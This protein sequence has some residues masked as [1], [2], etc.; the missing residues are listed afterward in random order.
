MIDN[1]R[2][3]FNGISKQFGKNLVLENSS[4]SIA[5]GE[6]LLITGDNGVGKTTLLR[7]IAGLEKP[8][9]CEVTIDHANPESWR[10]RANACSNLLCICISNPIC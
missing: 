7:I 8:N 5:S 6:C 2:F 3:L 1:F 9:H 10:N 4:L